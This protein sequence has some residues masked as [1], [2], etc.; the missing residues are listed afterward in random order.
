MK[1]TRKPRKPPP[2][3][4]AN[5]PA[6]GSAL[7]LSGHAV[8]CAAVALC[9]AVAEEAESLLADLKKAVRAYLV[10]RGDLPRLPPL[11]QG[12]PLEAGFERGTTERSVVP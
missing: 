7:W 4:P 11:K 9:E 3:D 5:P 10:A 6:L 8:T 1:T 2:L 12:R